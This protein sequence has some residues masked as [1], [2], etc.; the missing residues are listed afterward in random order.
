MAHVPCGVS[1][2][3]AFEP[4]TELKLGSIYTRGSRLDMDTNSVDPVQTPLNDLIDLVRQTALKEIAVDKFSGSPEGDDDGEIQIWSINLVYGELRA[5]SVAHLLSIGLRAVLPDKRE[6]AR[7]AGAG[8]LMPRF[9]DLG[10]GEGIP[11]LTAAMR[12]ANRLARICGIELLPRLHRVAKKH[13]ALLY[14]L[15]KEGGPLSH[16][17]L[18]PGDNLEDS[19]NALA[20]V[21]LICGSFLAEPSPPGNGTANLDDLTCYNWPSCFDI[22][23]CNGTW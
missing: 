4:S 20:R 22:V 10:S 21:E 5:E 1:L 3:L 11:C 9:L 12:F 16:A 23:L 2:N 18:A 8:T 6:Q 19:R 14:E 13:H 7:N 15:L 17:A